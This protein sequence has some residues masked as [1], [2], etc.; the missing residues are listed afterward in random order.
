[1]NA[2]IKNLAAQMR[3]KKEQGD[4]KFVLLLGAGASLSSGVPPTWTIMSEL[5]KRYDNENTG[6]DIAQRFDQL[7]NRTP[8]T[9]RRGFLQPYLKLPN[10]PS[11]G[12]A[13]LAELIRAGYFDLAVTF[14]FDDL[15]ETSLKN[16]GFGGVDDMKSLI[17]GETIPETMQKLVDALENAKR[18]GGAR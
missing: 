18:R 17:R 2:R 9:M 10:P 1:M 13:K 15:L 14:N 6:G 7:W 16:I 4:E 8:D 5:L 3:M 12:Y 11:T